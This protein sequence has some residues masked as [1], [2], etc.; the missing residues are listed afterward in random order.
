MHPRNPPYRS[1]G[2]ATPPKSES[3]LSLVT[4]ELYSCAFSRLKLVVR[5]AGSVSRWR[6]A[7]HRCSRRAGEWRAK[8]GTPARTRGERGRQTHLGESALR[9]LMVQ[10][11]EILERAARNSQAR[12]TGMQHK[13]RRHR[14]DGSA[15][16]D[17][18]CSHRPINRR[19]ERMKIYW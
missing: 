15:L 12:R 4:Q 6:A 17:R 3:L 7:P 2:S 11:T 19:D 8:A 14:R 5:A 18:N 13:G 10:V 16:P 9:D 1:A